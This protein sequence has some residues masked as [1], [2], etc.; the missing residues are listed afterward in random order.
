MP[1][2]PSEADNGSASQIPLPFMEPEVS[3]AFPQEAATGP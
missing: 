2:S 1:W 3:L